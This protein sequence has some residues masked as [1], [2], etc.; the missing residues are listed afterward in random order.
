MFPRS[1]QCKT[2]CDNAAA[3]AAAKA[4]KTSVYCSIYAKAENMGACKTCD[5]SCSGDYSDKTDCNFGC[6]QFYGDYPTLTSCKA[7]CV[8]LR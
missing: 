5:A 7:H 2:G 4:K 1:L 6:A 3:V 8:R